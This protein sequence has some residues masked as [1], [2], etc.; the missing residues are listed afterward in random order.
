MWVYVNGGD[1]KFGDIDIQ[2]GQLLLDAN[3]FAYTDTNYPTSVLTVRSNGVFAMT[4]N[5]GYKFSKRVVIQP[6]GLFNGAAGGSGTLTESL[7]VQ[8]STG[9]TNIF[10]ASNAGTTINGPV[11]GAGDLVLAGA[12]QL[13]LNG[14]NS[15][16][17]NTLV[18]SG[19][20]SLGTNA[21]ISTTSVISVMLGG[22]FD[23]S[24]TTY[25][26]VWTQGPSQS[27]IGDGQVYGNLIINGT[28]SP[29]GLK[30]GSSIGTL[31]FN[32]ND[33]VTLAGTTVVEVNKDNGV[34]S[35]LLRNLSG[36]FT[37][38]GTLQVRLTGA[39]PL[40]VG[41]TF[42]LFEASGFLGA[43][44]T[45]QLPQGYSWDTSQLSVSGAVTVAAIGSP[46]PP[47]I[48]FVKV[49]GGNLTLVGGGGVPGATFQVLSSTNLAAPRLNWL[50]LMTNIFAP[51]G[52]F[53]NLIPV[54]PVD[55]QRYYGLQAP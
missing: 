42:Y 21:T 40:A 37:Y 55:S 31:Y 4:H 36:T 18:K 50:P 10:L 51:D 54:N 49:S 7:E 34:A 1:W 6:G 13:T 26:Y 11:I 3:Y 9:Q 32:Y 44:A 39:A 53:T 48:S 20:L 15:Y 41:D 22:V 38:G 16:S 45:I 2:A 14:T 23:P 8:G 47:S 35:D 52:G 28:V 12:G 46:T 30:T 24:G 25:P 27:L 17:G 33:N 5:G 19:T 43:F 29:A